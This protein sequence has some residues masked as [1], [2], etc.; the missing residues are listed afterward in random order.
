MSDQIDRSPESDTPSTEAKPSVRERV[1]GTPR[2]KKILFAMAT[3]LVIAGAVLFFT[4]SKTPAPSGGASGGAI[5]GVGLGASFDAQGGGTSG[6]ATESAGTQTAW[7]E[8]FFRLGLSFFVG[9]TIGYALRSVV[10]MALIGFGLVFL[11]L[12]ALQYF[13]HVEII[14]WHALDGV[15]QTLVDR[16]KDEATRFQSFV[17]GSL[18]S[19]GLATLGLFTGFKK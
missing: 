17:T 14:N 19:T 15:F 7:S 3:L 5:S 13:A 2:W 11:A 12:F 16:V 9:F 18:P 8:G 4:E 6:G 10:K 1:A